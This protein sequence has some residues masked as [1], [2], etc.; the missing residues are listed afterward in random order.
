MQMITSI[1]CNFIFNHKQY[2][3]FSKHKSAER[4]YQRDKSK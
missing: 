2:A 4:Y 3:K 1:I